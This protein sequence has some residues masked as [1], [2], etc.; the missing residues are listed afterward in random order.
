MILRFRQINKD[1]FDAIRDG[2]KKIETRAGSPK[3]ASLKKGDVISFVC[4]KE[5]FD[6]KIRKVV[7]FQDIKSLHNIYSP[8][9][10]NPKTKTVKESEKIYYSFPGYR[11]KIKKYGLVAIEL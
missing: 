11:Q 4:G 9:E 1:I 8:V 6:R 3:Y 7:R 10:I 2:K 5:R